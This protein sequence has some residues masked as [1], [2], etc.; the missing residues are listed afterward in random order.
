LGASA[1]AGGETAAGGD[2]GDAAGTSVNNM[3]LL[4]D[5][6]MMEEAFEK[7]ETEK[8]GEEE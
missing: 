2:A 8:E 3:S 5:S 1:S 7:E 6:L 4:G